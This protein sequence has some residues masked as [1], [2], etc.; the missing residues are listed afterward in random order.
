[1]HLLLFLNPLALSALNDCIAAVF[2]P[3][4]TK[5]CQVLGSLLTPTSA[6]MLR[7]P[8]L[9]I[10]ISFVVIVAGLRIIKCYFLN[11][12]WALE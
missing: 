3:A 5:L 12:L 1:M 8:G 4:C 2:V 7:F 11:Y 6:S 10:F 9:F